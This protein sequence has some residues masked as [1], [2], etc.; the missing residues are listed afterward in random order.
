MSDKSPIE[1]II[2]ISLPEDMEREIGNFTIDPS[3]L[4]PVELPPGGKSSLQIENL[5]W[6]MIIS[7]MLK[8]L[9]H[10]P[11][12]EDADYYRNFIL[13]AKP[14][15]VTELSETAILKARNK[16]YPLAEEI[17]LAL[18][19]LLPD[20]PAML[21][22]LSL[23]YEQ[24]A[25]AYREQGNEIEK[26]KH[27]ERAFQT[28]KLLFAGE[29]I[30]PDAHL[31]A[32]FF[33]MK[34]QNYGRALH[35][36]KEY[37]I[38]GEDEEK[39]KTA[40]NYIREIENQSLMDTLFKEAYDFIKLGKEEEGIEKIVKFLD[41]YPEVWNGWFILGWGKRRKG[42][43]AEA[44]Q[45]FVKAL[46]LGPAQTDTLNELAICRMELGKYNE[47]RKNLETALAIEPENTKIIS[48]LAIL[49]LKEDK[50]E[51]ALGFFNTVL[52]I[53]PEDKIAQK[54]RD[55]LS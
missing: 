8:I 33:L 31:N 3:K 32:A 37:L 2:Y 12:H 23:L 51:E 19:G 10:Q 40:E 48:N 20:N 9:A 21:V 6:E 44:E 43:Y 27:E 50:K 47:S 53:D 26:S 17:F 28:Y 34:L 5:S 52:E 35:H 13:A 18:R 38:V 29:K 39:R 54:Y 7:G 30:P 49:S 25:D 22:N 45:A 36:L 41:Q 1:N 24:W 55:I 11:A 46:E 16:D 42:E 14:N 4:I 15:I